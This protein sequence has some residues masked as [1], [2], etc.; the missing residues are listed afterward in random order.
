M[1]EQQ[2]QT[3]SY[4]QTVTDL[5]AAFID[6]WADMIVCWSQEKYLPD[7]LGATL[8][9]VLSNSDVPI[10]SFPASVL[11]SEQ[12]PLHPFTMQF[13]QMM[14][15]NSAAPTASMGFLLESLP[16]HPAKEQDFAEIR[17]LLSELERVTAQDMK[18]AFQFAV[19]KQSLARSGQTLEGLKRYQH[20]PFQPDRLQGKVIHKVGGV[21]LHGYQHID[22][23][24]AP[25]KPLLLIPS[26]ING[27]EIFD[28]VPQRSFLRY[29]IDAGYCPYVVDWGEPD[30][31]SVDFSLNDYIEKRL[32]PLFEQLIAMTGRAVPVVGYCMGGTLAAALSCLYPNDV[33]G[34]A[35]LAAPW[36]FKAAPDHP[37]SVHYQKFLPFLQKISEV[38]EGRAGKQ[39]QELSPEQDLK[40]MNVI[41]IELLQYFFVS[42]NPVQSERKFRQF[43]QM[44]KEEEASQLFVALERWAN[45]GAPVNAAVIRQAVDIWFGENLP[46]KGAWS[47]AGQRI[48]PTKLSCPV[49]VVSPQKDSLVPPESS[50]ALARIMTAGEMSDTVTL[51]KPNVGHVGLMVGRQAKD[52]L[53]KPFVTWLDKYCDS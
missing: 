41:P 8:S 24:K 40:Q 34:L 53:Y 25:L 12:N 3:I 46:A 21:S 5:A 36:D 27:A 28:L 9:A 32:A 35:V 42:L 6:H 29:L 10:I 48:D 44:T 11:A 23:Q 4:Q 7:N 33:S 51:L 20:Y 47:V 16:I 49:F 31:N 39:E 43:S 19:V 17:R 37:A 26:M 45:M 52:V 14:G 13:S 30:D 50:C 1:A 22:S 38:S 2:G 15:V 18:A